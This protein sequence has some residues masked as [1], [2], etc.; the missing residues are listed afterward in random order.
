MVEIIEIVEKIS[1]AQKIK[2]KKTTKQKK[3]N[4]SNLHFDAHLNRNILSLYFLLG[5]VCVQFLSFVF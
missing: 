3:T 4:T 5:N 1:N 2:K